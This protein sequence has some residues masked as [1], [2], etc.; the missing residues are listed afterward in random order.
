MAKETKVGLLAGLA[1]IVCFAV[2]LSNRRQHPLATLTVSRPL[3]DARRFVDS[4]S[5]VKQPAHRRPNTAASNRKPATSAVSQAVRGGRRADL[6]SGQ[7]YGGDGFTSVTSRGDAPA[8]SG[9]D[10]L[11]TP[12]GTAAART[13][14]DHRSL[15]DGNEPLDSL[16]ARTS[17]PLRSPPD[18]R[19]RILQEHLDR[20]NEQYSRPDPGPRGG[21]LKQPQSPAPSLFSNRNGPSPTPPALRKKVEAPTASPVAPA[22]VRYVVQPGDS[23]WKIAAKHYRNRSPAY[24]DAIVNANRDTISDPNEVRAGVEL[25]LPIIDGSPPLPGRPAMHGHT[26]SGGRASPRLSPPTVRHDQRSFRWYQ[27]EK[28]DRYISIARRQLGDASRW[29][30]LY[31]LNRDKFPDPQLIREGVRIKLPVEQTSTARG[32]RS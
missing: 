17:T 28:N 10:V 11:V 19:R 26:E 32:G 20:L 9:A 12:V 16:T 27:I 23:L 5:R 7:R 6:P 21:S 25:V 4:A 3:G 2:I 30:E 18:E 1:F 15:G 13:V 31:E 29:P 8:G 22:F 24:I 14:V